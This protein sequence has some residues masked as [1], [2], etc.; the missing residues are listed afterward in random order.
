MHKW[1]ANYPPSSFTSYC[2]QIPADP[3]DGLPLCS[4]EPAL[5]HTSLRLLCSWPGGFPSPSLHWTGDL[6]SAGQQQ[7]NEGQQTNPMSLNILLPSGGLSF[8]S[9]SFT[10]HG[11]HP[12]LKQQTKCSTLT[13]ESRKLNGNYEWDTVT[14]V[15]R[16][17][18]FTYPT[19]DTPPAEPV[20]IANVTDDK[21]FLILSCSWVGGFPKGLLWW[22]GPS[23]Q[24]KDGEESSNILLVRYNNFQFGKPYICYA[25]HPLLVQTKTC[26]L[27]LG[28][29]F[30]W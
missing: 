4:V 22:K 27:R 19:L 24:G 15:C 23:G 3:P 18:H 29:C 14:I 11:S 13:C 7:V 6:I 16:L 9:S 20:C 21:Q 25:K 1:L 26:G 5:N 10:C 8:N 30:D 2:T 17:N 12:V 28:Q